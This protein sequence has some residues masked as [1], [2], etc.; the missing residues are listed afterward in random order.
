MIHCLLGCTDGDHGITSAFKLTALK[1]EDAL[2]VVEDQDRVAW[3]L[4]CVLTHSASYFVPLGNLTTCRNSPSLR[5]AS[6]NDSYS[7]GLVTYTLQPSS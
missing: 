4:I 5:I 1:R 6:M 2:V 7:T 3:R